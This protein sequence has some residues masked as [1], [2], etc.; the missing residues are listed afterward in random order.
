ML[1]LNYR[2]GADVRGYFVWSLMD[3]YEWL[4]GYN[5]RFGLY[6]VDR[7]TLTRIT[8]LS[9]HW[10]KDFLTNNTDSEVIDKETSRLK[11]SF[12]KDVL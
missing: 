10:Y 3:S 11:R 5:V 2:D 7:K 9:A 1:F 12:L 8:K 4:Q 6:Y